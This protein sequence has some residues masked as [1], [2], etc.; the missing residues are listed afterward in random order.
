MD[1]PIKDQVNIPLK[2]TKPIVC[3]CGCEIFDVGASLR[4]VSAI[5]SP[6]GKDEVLPVQTFYCKKCFKKFEPPTRSSLI[7]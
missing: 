6:S 7:V 2:D 1:T 4:A 5:V 3:E